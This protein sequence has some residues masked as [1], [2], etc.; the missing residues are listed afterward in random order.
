MLKLFENEV[1]NSWLKT[2]INFQ[3]R[4]ICFS[5]VFVYSFYFRVCFCFVSFLSFSVLHNFLLGFSSHI[6]LNLCDFSLVCVL[7]RLVLFCLHKIL[8]KFVIFTVIE[9]SFLLELNYI[10]LKTIENLWQGDF[11]FF[12]SRTELKWLN[13]VFYSFWSKCVD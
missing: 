2:K 12:E 3:D 13:L 11:P 10:S 1:K 5:F 8:A 9:I 6:F 7:F 4:T